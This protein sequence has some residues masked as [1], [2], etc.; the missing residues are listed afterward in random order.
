MHTSRVS[1]SQIDTKRLDSDYYRPEH[2]ETERILRGLNAEPLKQVGTFWAGPFGSE[3]PS[4]L[5][6][7]QGGPLFRVGNVGSLQVLYDGM[8]HLDPVVHKELSASEVRPGDLLVVK[9]SVGEK[10]C[11]I[12]DSMPQANITQHIIA[13]RPNGKADADYI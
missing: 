2:L 1:P 3:L 4:S 10:I 12:P 8:A 9:A 7:N 5:Y 6:L 11:R 13:I